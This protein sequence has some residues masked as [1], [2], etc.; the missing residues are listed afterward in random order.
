MS[1]GLRAHVRREGDS[2]KVDEKREEELTS[3]YIEGGE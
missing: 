1:E 2:A 3:A